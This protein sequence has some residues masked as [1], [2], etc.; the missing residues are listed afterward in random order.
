MK[1]N[2][3]IPLQIN[4]IIFFYIKSPVIKVE[5]CEKIIGKHNLQ[6]MKIL[7]LFQLSFISRRNEY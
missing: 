4:L 7:N 1:K 3:S 2:F 6:K 5:D